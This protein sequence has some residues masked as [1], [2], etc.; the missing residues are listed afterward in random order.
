MSREIKFRG[1]SIKTNKW[2]YGDL[3]HTPENKKRIIWFEPKGEIPL[4]VDYDSFNEI[5]ESGSVGQFTGLT[6][7]NGKEIYEG[8]VLLFEGYPNESI[9]FDEGS[10]GYKGIYGFNSLSETNLSI[11][12]VIGNIYETPELLQS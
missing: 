7:K 4:D 6:D 9:I 2:V 3:I 11:A 12:E 10:F 1:K 5:V 8:D